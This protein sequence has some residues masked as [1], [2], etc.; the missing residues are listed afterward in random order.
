[1]NVPRN[2]RFFAGAFT[3]PEGRRIVD[4][5]VGTGVLGLRLTMGLASND[6][7]CGNG[8]CLFTCP[9]IKSAKDG[10]MP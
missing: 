10:G 9:A 6:I 2:F 8:E 3:K 7:R 5:L 4:V 1:M